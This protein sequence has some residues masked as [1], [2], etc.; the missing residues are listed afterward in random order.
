MGILRAL[1]PEIGTT[2]ACSTRSGAEARVVQRADGESLEVRDR[3]GRLVFE[4]DPESGRSTLSVPTGDLALQAPD[5]HIDLVAAR[6]V[7]CRTPGAIDL[8]SATAVSLGVEGG[9]A[10][11]SDLLLGPGVARWKAPRIGIQ[12]DDATVGVASLRYRGEKLHAR[13]DTLLLVAGRVETAAKRILERAVNV[14]R[15]VEALHQLRAGRV[16]THVE[17]TH[18]VQA[19]TSEH[20]TRGPV[21]IDGERIELG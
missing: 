18:V 15:R 19:E 12:A 17:G 13:L 10:G 1:R 20:R 2:A 4:Y 11:R 9:A 3:E 7:R 14:Y 6:G 8:A 16:R 5:G 21:R